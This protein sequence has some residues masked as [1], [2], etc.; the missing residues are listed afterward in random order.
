MSHRVLTIAQQKGGA[1]KSTL[2][3]HIAVGLAA[4]GKRVALL[5]TDPQG[6]LTRWYEIRDREMEGMTGLT[7]AAVSGW[8]VGSE[9]HRL[10]QECDYVVIDSPPHVEAEARSAIRQADMA[11]L[12]MQPSP[13]DFWATQSTLELARAE[14]VPVRIVLNRV[15]PNTRLAQMV[16]SEMP[17]T[18]RTLIG[19]RVVFASA[20]MQG[21][22]ALE[23]A[24]AS[25]AAQEIRELTAE[26]MDWLKRLDQAPARPHHKQLLGEPA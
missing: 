22:T 7:F 25:P 15:I 16:K 6:T 10:K 26:V 4:R 12:P 2:A 23:T 11:L 17:G 9:V 14:K 21:R 1:G 8:R 13:A 19:N 18:A 5:D 20:L 3:A 24:P